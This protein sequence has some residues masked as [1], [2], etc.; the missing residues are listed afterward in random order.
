[1]LEL[2][3][4]QKEE[5]LKITADLGEKI[6]GNK[7]IG[8]LEKER[9][10]KALA[11]VDENTS[12]ADLQKIF[13]DAGVDINTQGEKQLKDAQSLIKIQAEANQLT[14]E[15]LKARQRIRDAQEEF[16]KSLAGANARRQRD[17]KN[18]ERDVPK[19]LA[20]NLEDSLS[21]TF[22]NLATGAYDSLG[23][24]FLGIALD[25][26]R[27][28]QKEISAAAAKS[29]V[30][31][32]SGGSGSGL[33]SG[34]G[35]FFGKAF[36]GRNAGG[37]ITGGSGV[38]DDVPAALTGGEYVIK[39]SAVQKY[40]LDFMEKLNSGYIRPMQSGGLYEQGAASAGYA[41][42]RFFADAAAN[43]FGGSASQ[44]RLA[45]ARQ[46]QFFVPGTRGAGV[47]RGKENLLAFAEQQFTSGQTDVIRGTATGASINLEDQSVRLTAFG[48][49]RMS[50]AR[51]AL[52]DAQE[53]AFGL[54]Q[55]RV[56][57]ER[58]VEQI[59]QDAKTARRKA[60]QSAVVGAFVNAAAAGAGSYFQ[61]QGGQ[62]QNLSAQQQSSIIDYQMLGKS[63]SM[64]GLQGFSGQGFN[65]SNY[66]SSALGFPSLPTRANGGDIGGQTNSLLMGG[67]YIMSS[68]AVSQLGRDTLD[69]INMMRF[70]NGGSVGNVASRSGGSA[71]GNSA[72]IGEV[73]ITI[74][75]EKGDASVTTGGSGEEDPT[76][77]K[78]FAK[79]V[80]EVVINVIN[81][82]KRVSGSLFS[83][84]R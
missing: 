84:K 74:N 55:S 60:F 32:F 9:L 51:I 79:R 81:E 21:N 24:A 30:S 39:K 47:I 2:T 65:S 46:T 1:L 33:F 73:N 66:T 28:L 56:E 68:R 5:Q 22:D 48:R 6:I 78:E 43:R 37:L 69:D 20:D 49:Q 12:L 26:G 54:F 35:N 40:G 10:D 64:A 59:K 8:V 77:T 44:E 29:I 3:F 27:A 42:G 45:Q 62:F 15:E 80:K 18:L 67:E 16:N 76:K 14:K 63:Q 31:S 34:I 11:L 58:R 13:K 53:K 23:D 38:R 82:E 57:E 41:G 52:L 25:F 50:P 71:G 17:L 72:D 36:Q 61:A 7:E 19:R 75:M 70:Q 4:K 83:R